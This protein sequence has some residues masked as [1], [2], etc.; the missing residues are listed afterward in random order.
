ML[1][2]YP[3]VRDLSLVGMRWE[4]E[5]YHVYL[6]VRGQAANLFA[7]QGCKSYRYVLR[8]GASPS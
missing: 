2:N 7:G 3:Q 6:G 1:P 8:V 5:F 4:S